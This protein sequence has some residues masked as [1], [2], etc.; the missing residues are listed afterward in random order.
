MSSAWNST[1]FVCL[2]V[3]FAC[4]TRG[5]EPLEPIGYATIDLLPEEAVSG[6]SLES[7]GPARRSF[8]SASF[9]VR[10]EPAQEGFETFEYWSKLKLTLP[11]LFGPPPPS[12]SFD[13]GRT[14]LDGIGLPEFYTLSLGVNW[15]RPVNDNWAWMFSFTPGVAT[16]FKNTTSDMWRFRGNAFAFYTPREDTQWILGAVV[17]GR[18]D[19]PAVPAIG[20][21]WWPDERS[22][23]DFTFPQPRFSHR[24]LERADREW[25]G[26]LG[27]NLGGGTWAVELPNGFDDIL[28]YRA[29]RLVVG[30]ESVPP[31]SKA[32]GS[33]GTAGLSS[34]VEAGI[35]LGREIEFELTPTKL[36]PEDAFYVAGGL[37]F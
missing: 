4:P 31:G 25:W 22:K 18:Q 37:R 2:L 35:S 14:E 24:L 15:I 3:S 23:L 9:D 27:S 21:V 8:V 7:L 33:R 36:T 28:T 26:Y 32:P 30:I 1:L 11:P 17:T 29:W 34:Y 13:V 12:L 10:W 20:L 5:S 16:D 6:E 19:L